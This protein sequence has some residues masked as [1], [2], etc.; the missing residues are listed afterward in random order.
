MQNTPSLTTDYKSSAYGLL[1]AS[2]IMIQTDKGVSG[3]W[4]GLSQSLMEHIQQQTGGCQSIS[5]VDFSI[6][7]YS[8]SSLAGQDIV[9]NATDNNYP[10]HCPLVYPD[11]A[12]DSSILAF[13]GSLNY[14]VNQGNALHGIGQSWET[15]IKDTYPPAV[16]CFSNDCYEDFV[17]AYGWEQT[18]SNSDFICTVF[19]D[20]SPSLEPDVLQIYV[21]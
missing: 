3:H 6:V 12:S 19:N 15:N 16:E 17:S 8:H 14:G 2:E 20:C 9:I 11:D 13:T 21:R 7:D 18:S 5:T 4:N 10:G 1:Q